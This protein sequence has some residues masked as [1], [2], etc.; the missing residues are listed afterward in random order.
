MK[1]T[2]FTLI[3]NLVCLTIFLCVIG[4]IGGVVTRSKDIN[5]AD[6]E[7]ISPWSS[8]EYEN[9]KSQRK[10]ANELKR[11]NDLMERQLKQP[12]RAELE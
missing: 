5:A 11:Q 8:V 10:I 4:L 3:D 9:A 1:K 7:E 2:G 6:E 12:K